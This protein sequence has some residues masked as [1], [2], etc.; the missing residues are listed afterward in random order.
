M[1]NDFRLDPRDGRTLLMTATG[2]HLGPTIFRSTNRGKTWKECKRPPKFSAGPKRPKG[3]RRDTRGLSVQSVFWLEPGHADEPGVWYA[4]T[5]PVGLFRSTDGGDTWRGVKGFNEHP[6]WGKWTGGGSNATPG[7]S[8]LHSIRVDP[9][10]PRHMYFSMSVGGTFESL[11]RGRTWRPLNQGVEIDF[12]PGP[13][14]EYGQDPHC[15]IVHPADPDRLYQQNHCG[16]YRLDRNEGEVW[17][18][19]GR[20]MPKK[21]GDIGFPIV[22]HP[23][24]PDIVW[25]F[26]MDG[27]Q[28]WPRTSPD[29]KPAVYRT[30]DGGKSWKRLDKGLPKQNAWYTVFRQAMTA[31]DE[32]R[33]TGVYFGTTSGDVWASLDAGGSWKRLAEALPRIHS[34]RFVTFR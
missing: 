3:K 2:G 15:M 30:L 8:L 26:P 33:K 14:P 34:L 17:T 21:I 18:R 1:V 9:R 10:D 4:G 27:T 7:G 5:N 29:G 16:I 6:S 23:T 25:V 22:P 19:I 12:L 32:P 20:R 31:D 24:D 13:P 28:I 11:D